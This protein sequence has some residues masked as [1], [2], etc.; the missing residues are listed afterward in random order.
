MFQ[1]A[2][3][4]DRT[5]IRI[6]VSRSEVDLLDIRAEY[7]RMYGRS[8]YQDITV[9]L[10]D[11]IFPAMTPLMLAEH[12]SLCWAALTC[13]EC[14]WL[15]WIAACA[16]S[17]EA[18]GQRVD[19]TWVCVGARWARDGEEANGQGRKGRLVQRGFRDPSIANSLC[20]LVGTTQS[21][22][23]VTVVLYFICVLEEFKASKNLLKDCL[24]FLLKVQ[25]FVN[26]LNFRFFSSWS[27]LLLL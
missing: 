14:S 19:S 27:T 8:L 23:W 17:V 10:G 24:L 3:T 5:L 7:K 9:R 21:S 22:S 20:D 6:M 1:G 4:K 18:E 25:D 11:L 15:C 12:R 2:G 16:R 26:R 13:T